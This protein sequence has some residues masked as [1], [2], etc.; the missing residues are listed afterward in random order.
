MPLPLPDR[1]H[2]HRFAASTSRIIFS[3][4]ERGVLYACTPP[5]LTEIR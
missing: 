5:V 2:R 4:G 1:G 3:S